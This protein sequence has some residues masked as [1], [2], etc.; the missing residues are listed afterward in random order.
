MKGLFALTGIFA[1]TLL[2]AGTVGEKYTPAERRHWSFR[3]RVRTEPPKF[4]DAAAKGWVRGP[5][6]AF[7]LDK[8]R[9]EGLQPAPAADRVALIRRVTFDLTGLPPTPAEVDAFLKDLSPTAYEKLVDRLL[10]SPAYGERWATHW[11]DVVRFAE[12]D[13]FEYDTH[14][15]DAWRYRDYVIKAFNDDKPY[16]QFVREQL[17]GD[18]MDPK[19]EELRIASGFNRLGPLRKNAGNQEVASSRNEVLT[20]MTN[21]VGSGLLGVTLGCARCHDH[22]FDPIRHT[23][24]Y[25]MQAFFAGTHPNDVPLASEAEQAAWKTKN[26]AHG[27]EMAAMKK[28]MK[29]LA[30]DGLK[31]MEQKL[32]DLEDKAPEPLPSLYAVETDRAKASPVH[33]LARGDHQNKGQAVGMRT[34]GVLLPEDAPELSVEK[35]RTAL[36]E[37][38][39]A[40]GNP[41][42]ARVAVNR[43]WNYHFGRGIVATPNDFGRMGVRPT[44]PELLDYLANRF[45]EGG[46]KW[47]PL[48]REILLS[49]TYRQGSRN[50][51][52][53]KVAEEKDPEN[54]LLWKFTRRRLEAE[55]I[56][57]AMLTVAGR[58]N[59][60]VGGPSIIVPV[61]K[62]LLT[63]LYKPSQWA[64]TQDAT[65][66]NRRSVY[67]LAKRNLR[68]P[69]MEVFDAP[70]AQISCARRESSTHAPQALE[71]LNGDLSNRLSLDLTERLQ[72]EGGSDKLKQID[73][74]YRI[75]T[76][77]PPTVKQR[78]MAL[79]F[80]RTQPLREF[81]L[82]VLNLNQFLY[83]E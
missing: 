4:A 18:E 5:I 45:V 66:H 58:L 2:I 1:A 70:D 9:K 78:Q 83:V 67:L 46:W 48:H 38:I 29:G 50:P 49:S 79:E 42:T 40:A 75:A 62:E 30:G 53:A 76:G 14:R 81:A 25:R 19:N 22:K 71:L 74:A 51:V 16:D 43:M 35:P 39:T 17:A 63:L 60:K 34:L 31:S 10:A 21:V 33:V 24:Y 61:D 36:A 69:F 8:L 20:E 77:R 47:K 26:E 32:A 52:S 15:R 64:V 56:R 23:D 3:E 37:W 72:T 54:K 11:L 82:A 7:I 59:R 68:L 80:L 13:G 6:D 73:L 57:D 12:S 28:A 55:E 65:E 41:L 27:K 44:H